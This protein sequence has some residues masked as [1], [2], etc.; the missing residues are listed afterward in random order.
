ME[1]FVERPAKVKSGR[2]RKLLWG[3]GLNDANYMVRYR[4]VG[5][6]SLVCPFYRKWK[7][8]LKRCYSDRCHARYPTY[9][10]CFVH[11]NWHTFSVFRKWM[12]QRDWEGK[13]LDKDLLIKGNKEYSPSSCIFVSQKINTLLLSCSSARGDLPQGVTWDK[14]KNKYS[15]RI[16]L[17]GVNQSL[18]RFSSQEEAERVYCKAKASQVQT[19]AYEEEA[20]TQPL[21]Q[22]ALLTVAK[23]FTDRYEYLCPSG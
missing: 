3:V 7:D 16:R 20:S 11:K 18:G 6:K 12:E 21:L 23:G 9:K 8:M 13:Q 1:K 17:N 2:P 15:S 19:I 5:G 14:T 4:G 10:G 22:E